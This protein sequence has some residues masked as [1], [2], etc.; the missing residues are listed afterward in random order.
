MQDA[1]EQI[2]TRMTILNDLDSAIGLRIA[3][4]EEA[5]RR[6]ISIRVSLDLGDDRSL[7]FG[8]IDGAWHLI[9]GEGDEEVRLSG[10][11]RDI[12]AEMIGHVEALIRCAGEQIEE[13]ISDRLAAIENADRILTALR[14][15]K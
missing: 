11:S 14:G 4:I 15:T 8:K 2:G 1:L 10:C 6:H 13:R 9:Y 7:D 5:L 3:S 12:R